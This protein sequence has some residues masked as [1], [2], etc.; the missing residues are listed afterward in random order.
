MA[1]SIALYGTLLGSSRTSPSSVLYK[2]V[3]SLVGG[4]VLKQYDIGFDPGNSETAAVVSDPDGNQAVRTCPSYFCRGSFD[5]LARFRTMSGR[6]QSIHPSEVLQPDE[7][8]LT[9]PDTGA[10]EYYVGELA[11]SQG[12]GAS[13]ARGDI[14]RYWSLIV[15]L[16]LLTTSGLCIPDDEYEANVVVGVP[17]ETYNDQNRRKVRNCLEG[18]HRYR[19]NGRQRRAVVYVEKII[20][21]GAGAMI[22]VG[23]DRSVRQ[24]VIDVGGRT[25]DL[26]TADGQM[27]LIPLCRGTALGVELAAD[28]LNATVQA[29][30]GRGLTQQEMRKILRATVGSGQYSSVYVYGQEVSPI[31]LR[32]WTEEALRSVG[33]DIA[34]FVSQTWAH[35]E[36]GA[37]AT[38]MARVLLVGGG[39]Y[40]FYPEIAKLIPHVTVPHQPE[41]ANALGYTALARHLRLRREGT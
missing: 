15:L 6:G 29:Q 41:L 13:S 37:V 16:L 33:R 14:S 8:V 35:G 17:I 25:T 20:M 27:P 2:T 22:A 26:Y 24:G 11:L 21:E 18:D 36:L 7:H 40:Y 34:T 5:S 38:D 4:Y 12:K 30:C 31:N 28:L 23:D 39:A 19:L 1:L 9:Y 3:L 10:S 32:L